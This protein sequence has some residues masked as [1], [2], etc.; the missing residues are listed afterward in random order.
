MGFLLY[1]YGLNMEME[2]DNPTPPMRPNW[3]YMM[4]PGAII[5]A[6]ILISGSVLYTRGTAQIGDQGPKTGTI[7]YTVKDITKWA[8]TIKGLD[9]KAFQQCLDADTYATRIAK[10]RQDG[11]TLQVDGTPTFFIN[12]IALVGAQPYANF[13]QAIDQTLADPK[14]AVPISPLLTLRSDDHILGDANAPVTIIE[15]SD[16]QCPFCR[17]FFNDTY[18]QLKKNYID[19]GKAKLVYRHFPLDFHPMAPK[20]AE[21]V[22]CAGAQNKFWEMHDAIFTLQAK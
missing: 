15:Y 3:T 22:E 10:D 4:L 19:T 13:Q 11:T 7:T 12:G 9:K 16:F 5:L 2:N 18:G 17:A 14:K 6:G 21:A 8:G 1:S 20:S